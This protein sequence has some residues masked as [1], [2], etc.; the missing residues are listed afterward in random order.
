MTF[1]GSKVKHF[2]ER[3]DLTQ[4]DLAAKVKVTQGFISDIEGNRKTPSTRKMFL[5]AQVLGVSLD[6]LSE[7]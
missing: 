2:R 5:I 6:D 7:K 1:S 3:L 4:A